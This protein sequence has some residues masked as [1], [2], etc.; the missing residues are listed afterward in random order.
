[1]KLRKPDLLTVDFRRELD[2]EFIYLT[3]GETPYLS[4][5]CNA[6][7]YLNP[8]LQEAIEQIRLRRK[9]ARFELAELSQDEQ[10]AKSDELDRSLGKARF[11]AIY[12]CCVADWESNIIDDETGKPIEATRDNFMM[13]AD[14]E[15]PGISAVLL[16]LAAYV[17]KASNFIRRADEETEKN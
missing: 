3:N 11:E 13:L 12:D 4:F 2:D 15:I 10:I 14:A 9:V 8:Q 1:M 6:G 7:G 17:E 5:K 16:E